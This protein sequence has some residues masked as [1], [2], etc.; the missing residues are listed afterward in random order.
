MAQVPN[1]YLQQIEWKCSEGLISYEEA[2]DF[3][4]ARVEGI[5]QGKQPPCVWFLEHPPLYTAG[6]SANAADMLDKE[7]FPIYEAGRGG[8]YTYHGPGQLVVYVM[9]DLKQLFSPNA[10]DLRAY[11]QWLERWIIRS[12]S[13][14]GVHGFTKEGMIGVWVDEQ[15][16]ERSE[17]V[18]SPALSTSYVND[19][20]SRSGDIKKIAA[21]GV[22]VRKWVSF[23]G[24]CINVNPDLSHYAGI[25][26]CG[27]KEY[28][29]TSL[30]KLGVNSSL[31][32]MS[33]VMQ[34]TC[35]SYS[36][37]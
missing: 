7:R 8:E 20:M 33:R 24:L 14:F 3:M 34:H 12:L 22:R 13:N 31:D 18:D 26:P 27:I 16:K 4:E 9:L 10:P 32:R 29:V 28:G 19:S 1:E 35:E 36:S 15:N 5:I 11:I 37:Q 30:E 17:S 23:H 25:V 2:L 21:I 6:T